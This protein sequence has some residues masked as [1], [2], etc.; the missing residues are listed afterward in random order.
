MD[1]DE[2]VDSDRL[3]DARMRI[4]RPRSLVLLPAYVQSAPWECALSINFWRIDK[5]SDR[6]ALS[7]TIN[8]N[9]L[10]ITQFE[11]SLIPS[12]SMKRRKALMVLLLVAIPTGATLATLANKR[13]PIE[14]F[15]FS[16][17]L[18][19]KDNDHVGRHRFQTW[20][21][22]LSSNY[23]PNAYHASAK[24]A[25]FLGSQPPKLE[26][27]ESDESHAF[28]ESEHHESEHHDLLADNNFVAP[29]GGHESTIYND[30]PFTRLAGRSTGSGAGSA[31]GSAGGGSSG[32]SSN[33]HSDAAGSHVSLDSSTSDASHL[34]DGSAPGS[35]HPEDSSSHDA[36]HHDEPGHD[37]AGHD[38]KHSDGKPGDGLPGF[39]ADSHH[40]D[41]GKPVTPPTG[42]I[43]ASTGDDPSHAGDHSDG[44]KTSKLVSVPEPSTLWLLAPM[45][46]MLGLR[47][48]HLVMKV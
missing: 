42:D 35:S 4:A 7:W 28:S 39:F 18:N 23:Q 34:D 26:V 14:K 40:D 32:S 11:S 19:L 3:L 22:A 29:Y 21:D 16:E 5:I 25:A 6:R 33:G 48:T 38:D 15:E 47:R 2:F 45:L 13:S 12:T 17:I 44:D 46:L 1:D 10:L 27:A 8:C 24:D 37:E 41:D 31:G 30:S 43:A 36:P 9:L 20:A